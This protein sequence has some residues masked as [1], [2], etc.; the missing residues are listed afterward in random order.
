MEFRNIT[1]GNLRVEKIAFI[2]LEA[3]G[4]GSSSFPTEI[5]WAIIPENGSVESGSCLIRP[6]GKWTMYGNAWSPASERLTGITREMLDRHGLPPSQAMKRCL[7]AVGERELFS[8]DPE[9]DSHWLSMLADAAGTSIGGRT[10][11]NA[12]KLIESIGA[13]LRPEGGT[14]GRADMHG[15]GSRS[16]RGIVLSQTLADW[17]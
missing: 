9:F 15:M 8:D 1:E 10:I 2:D 4:L 14:V 3:S 13:K 11:C 5:G 17:R 7:E 16:R 6:P 12:K